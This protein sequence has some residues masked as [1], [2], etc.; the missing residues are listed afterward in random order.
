M[1]KRHTWIFG[2]HSSLQIWAVGKG[3][4]PQWNM[5]FKSN[6]YLS[7]IP[8]LGKLDEVALK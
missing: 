5:L 2:S 8:L 1:Y 3:E 7:P 4:R 6:L